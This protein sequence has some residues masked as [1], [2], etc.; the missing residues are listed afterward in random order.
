MVKYKDYLVDWLKTWF[1]TNGRDSK[2]CVAISGGKDSTAVAALCV[3]ALGKDRVIGVLM[4][5][6]EQNDINDSYAVCRH[7]GIRF[8]EMNIGAAY[9]A[10]LTQFDCNDVTASEQTKVNLPARL[11]MSTLYAVA[12]SLNGRVVGT[13]NL[14]ETLLGFFTRWGDG[15]SDC[16]PIIKLH[17]NEVVEL[18]LILGVPEYLMR[19]TP[20]D[21]LGTIIKSDEEKFGFTYAEFQDFYEKH[22]GQ[23][24]WRGPD[25]VLTEKEEKMYTMYIK[26]TFKRRPIPAPSYFPRAFN[27]SESEQE[28]CN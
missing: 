24:G 10:V 8:L 21:G 9:N 1:E 14:D 7:L 16:E 18:G 3:E 13:S 12:Q 15:V 20:S 22:N 19:K 6:G 4:P 26:S 27:R 25:E 2:A 5:N 17:A 11:R 23:M 28:A